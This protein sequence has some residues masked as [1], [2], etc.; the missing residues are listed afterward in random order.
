EDRGGLLKVGQPEPFLTTSVQ[1]DAEF[2]PDGRWVAYL[3]NEVG[4]LQ[5]FVRPFPG[6]GG[7]WQISS[8][9]GSMPAWSRSELFYVD[10]TGRI[11]AVPYTTK[12]DAFVAGPRRVRWDGPV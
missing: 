10:A 4:T 5:V 3:S 12:G 11:M 2:S 9:G 6:P 8:G 1:A 7:K